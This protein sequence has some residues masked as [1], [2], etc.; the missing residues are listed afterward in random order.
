[1]TDINKTNLNRTPV[2][3]K[4]VEKKD[5]NNK[6]NVLIGAGTGLLGGGAV[7]GF[8]RKNAELKDGDVVTFMKNKDEVK[9][10][11]TPEA[12]ARAAILD[13]QKKE[14]DS[15]DTIA[16]KILEKKSLEKEELELL[17]SIGGDETIDPKLIE[18][19]TKEARVDLDLFKEPNVDLT[20]VAEKF[21]AKQI[22]DLNANKTFISELFDL[23]AKVKAE[24]LA[25]D[26]I[27]IE[28]EKLLEKH[29]IYSQLGYELGKDKEFFADLAKKSER[30]IA[31]TLNP[32]I[33]SSLTDSKTKLMSAIDASIKL[34]TERKETIV[35]DFIE[36]AKVDVKE[37]E[38]QV[39]E[40]AKCFTTLDDNGILNS[41]KLNTIKEEAEKALKSAKFKK[42]IAMGTVVGTAVGALAAFVLP[43]TKAE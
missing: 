24:N 14:L 33:D 26:Q 30:E 20:S 39:K 43:K 27:K 18:I 34:A 7:G 25:D 32:L 36:Q 17:K 19:Y 23:N 10:A 21:H 15:L 29:P 2:A 13:E 41:S 1:M 11:I 5:T 6:K 8:V 28:T 42:G 37:F 38:S 16:N 3:T 22:E 31:V 12:Q 4:N 35:K 40:K 9:N